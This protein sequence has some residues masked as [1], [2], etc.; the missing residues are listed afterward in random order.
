[1]A[2]FGMFAI[3]CGGSDATPQASVEPTVTETPTATASSL[4]ATLKEFSIEL[5][6]D[7]VPAGA[8][9]ID[10]EN[11]GSVLH[12]IVVLRTDLDPA[13]LPVRNGRVDEPAIREHGEILGEI[14]EFDPGTSAE[15]TFNLQPGKYILV[16]NVPG[17]YQS[18]MYTVLTVE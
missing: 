10:A 18:G 5:D 11:A 13:E 15:G 9:T 4:S 12:E 6:H 7:D 1:M 2:L 17:H 8:V 16:C 3:A 14:E